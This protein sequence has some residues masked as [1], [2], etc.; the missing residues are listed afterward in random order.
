MESTVFNG[1]NF[2][3]VFGRDQLVIGPTHARGGKLVLLMTD[4]PDLVRAVV[5]CTL[6]HTPQRFT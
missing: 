2:A 1:I 6:W 5:A 4:V 3:T